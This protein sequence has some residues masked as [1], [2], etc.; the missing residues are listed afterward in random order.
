M[1]VSRRDQY[2]RVTDLEAGRRDRMS[3][4]VQ[5]RKQK[6]GE[7]VQE[8]RAAQSQAALVSS[9]K[10]ESE[11]LAQ[12]PSMHATL[13]RALEV[14]D[15]GLLVAMQDLRRLV[16]MTRNPQLNPVMPTIPLVVRVLGRE[17]FGEAVH[18]EGLWILTNMASGQSVH[19]K[20]VVDCRGVETFM[21]FMH[22]SNADIVEQS[23]W[24]L[25]NVAG[26]C[27]DNRDELLVHGILPMLNTVMYKAYSMAHLRV[28]RNG[29]WMVSNLCRGHPVIGNEY[30]QQ[31]LPIMRAMCSSDTDEE[32]LCD[33]L[34]AFSY[35]TDC[36]AE[37]LD[38][39]IQ[40]S[41]LCASAVA[42]MSSVRAKLHKPAVRV[43]GNFLSSRD[44]HA[45][46]FIFEWNALDGLLARVE[47]ASTA[48]EAC[49]G[50]SN[51][52]AG[53]SA[54]I[55]AA[56]RLLPAVIRVVETSSSWDAR[57]EGAWCL[58]N[59]GHGG[60]AS[61]IRE[62][63]LDMGGLRA[64]V[65]Y[66]Q[67]PFSQMHEE[68]ANGL[69][70]VLDALKEHGGNEAFEEMGGVEALEAMQEK[71]KAEVGACVEELLQRFYREPTY[72]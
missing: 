20:H 40:E 66:L 24:G 69:C 4:S 51:V 3:A 21:R 22:H 33:A 52:F 7:R 31:A 14:G 16:S 64:L 67:G 10:T 62:G 70:G 68:I 50:L 39:L 48:Q 41:A 45:D 59:L 32:V 72:Q 36:N 28:L 56:M 65:K 37:R 2:K 47:D 35:L 38:G 15:A 44:A 25:S 5:I 19:T 58:L 61:E 11:L 71:C 42:C 54:Q 13:A 12:L 46:R 6:A 30:V 9:K 57:R 26:D 34:W 49:W 27:I 1:N 55:A 8:K 60:N 53:T 23:I 18:F 43:V 17:E 63:M 29:M